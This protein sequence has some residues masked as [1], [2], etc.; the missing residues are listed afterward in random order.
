MCGYEFKG[1]IEEKTLR[2]YPQISNPVG[3]MITLE[4]DKVEMGSGSYS[5]VYHATLKEGY[6]LGG[7]NRKQLGCIAFKKNKYT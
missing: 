7:K 1:E 6:T 5:E 3:V 2:V 4:Y